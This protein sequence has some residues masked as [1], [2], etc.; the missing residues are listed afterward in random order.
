[1]DEEELA[2]LTRF[3]T[4]S[5]AI[6][7]IVDYS[8][9]VR[10]QLLEHYQLGH[11]GAILLLR[12]RP[13]MRRPIDEALVRDVQRLI[14]AEQ[15]SKGHRALKAHEIGKWRIRN[16]DNE[17]FQAA[18]PW[19]RIPS[20][21]A[22]WISLASSAK[23]ARDIAFLHWWYERIHPFPDGNGRSGRALVYYLYRRAGLRPF[24]FTN[25]DKHDVYY[26]SFR[27]DTAELMERYFLNR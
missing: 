12:E 15:P 17:V 1:M 4:E 19:E 26:P 6:E 5:D 23:S 18:S 22:A 14:V 16:I 10:R 8:V 21:M 3:I 20:D 9:T 25:G 2:F 11:V 24:V 13:H 27:Q 7:G